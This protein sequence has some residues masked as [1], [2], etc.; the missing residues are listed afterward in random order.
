MCFKA[1]VF[2]CLFDYL[3]IVHWLLEYLFLTVWSCI[4][5]A[6]TGKEFYW[7]WWWAVRC[8]SFAQ[9]QWDLSTQSTHQTRKYPAHMPTGNHHLKMGIH[10]DLLFYH[11]LLLCQLLL[12]SFILSSAWAGHK[13]TT[14]C[15]S[16]DYALCC[17]LVE[18]L[19]WG[20][21]ERE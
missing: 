20:A 15:R 16:I 17:F 13:F 12:I 2:L 14:E 6:D 18:S 19:C 8:R 4:L 7:T 11:K 3:L 5:G 1:I 21:S 10:F 9:K